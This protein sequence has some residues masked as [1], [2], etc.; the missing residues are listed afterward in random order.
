MANKYFQLIIS[1]LLFSIISFHLTAQER[2]F[3]KGIVCDNENGAIIKNAIVKLKN[4]PYSVNTD[5]EGHFAIQ[6]QKFGKYTLQFSHLNYKTAEKGCI[7]GQEEVVFMN[8]M[9]VDLSEVVVTQRKRVSP[10]HEVTTEPLAW[11]SSITYL[12]SEDIQKM[13][14]VTAFDALKYST[15]GLPA[16]QG[17]RKK[18]FYL[19]RGQQA[20]SDYAVNGVSLSTNGDGPM[21]QWVEAPAYLPAGMIESMEVIRSGNSLLLG[22]SGLNG[23]VNIKTRTFKENETQAEIE[24]GTFN[25]FRAGV[26][27]GGSVKNFNYAFSLYRDRTDGPKGR[28]SLEDFWNFYGKIG[29][30]YKNLFEFNAESFYMYGTR[31]VTKAQDYKELAAP[32]HQLVEIWEYDP[33]RYSISTARFKVNE[34]QKASTELQLS[35]ILNRMDLYPDEYEFNPLS[36]QVVGDSI[37]RSKTMLSEPDSI[38]SVGLFQV[39]SPFKNNTIRAALMYASSANYTHGKSKKEI[40]TASLLDQHTFFDKLDA[41]IG[42]K[43]IREYYDYYVPNEGSGND[44]MAIR[45]QWQPILFNVSGGLSYPI[46]DFVF[47]GMM[48][49]GKL[50]VDQ[51]ALRRIQNEITGIYEAVKVNQE[52][53]T[54]ID[55]GAEYT[56][57]KLGN[58]V[59]T[60]FLLDQHNTAEFTNTPY[61]DGDG[62]IRYYMENINL[63]TYGVE[64]SYQ[65]PIF[66]N[67]FSYWGNASYKYLQ[68]NN[69]TVSEYKKYAKQPALILNA[70]ASY[71]SKRFMVNAMG[72]YVSQYKTDRFLSKEVNTGNYFN[73]DITAT[74]TIPRKPFQLY[75]SAINVFD[76]KYSTVSPLYPDFG[77]QFKIGLRFA[78][79]KGKVVNNEIVCPFHQM[80]HLGK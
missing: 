34:S 62:L 72:K 58:A 60:L 17:R 46:N 74:Y 18:H 13:G 77:R 79:G 37:I 3:L 15:D 50:P 69:D 63:R 68:Q 32:E 36:S 11:K 64:L 40:Y 42:A 5:E 67:G 27:N 4:Q 25:T 20:A 47:N 43:L 45:N 24:Y 14:A 59:F 54:G 28:H 9:D 39:I 6:V 75:G 23:V 51:S 76:K 7:V 65:T 8:K 41:H 80:R 2:L 10:L 33:M 1:C 29:Y 52:N 49:T 38:Y 71:V 22:F 56:T 55:L 61:Y 31:Y 12:N 19:L 66:Q 35:C 21:A 70:G 16:T 78:F 26:L 44:L 73:F 48:N 30:K 57:E 53:R